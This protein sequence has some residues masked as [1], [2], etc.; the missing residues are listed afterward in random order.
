MPAARMTEDVAIVFM[1]PPKKIPPEG[2]IR[3]FRPLENA[4]RPSS[5][6]KRRARLLEPSPKRRGQTDHPQS[7]ADTFSEVAAMRTTT[8]LGRGHSLRSANPVVFVV[9]AKHYSIVGES[10]KVA[11]A[12]DDRGASAR[13]SDAAARLSAFR[14][15]FLA[16]CHPHRSR[17]TQTA[18][19]HESHRPRA[20]SRTGGTSQKTLGSGMNRQGQRA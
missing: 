3:P 10:R 13:T 4:M 16:G 15:C 9:H 1:N 8:G 7:P 19:L 14:H 12:E 6:E 18:N 17:E 2:A 5:Q 11:L 20:L